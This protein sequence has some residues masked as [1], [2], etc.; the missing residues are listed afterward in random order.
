M[1]KSCIIISL[2]ALILSGVGFSQG[3]PNGSFENGVLPSSSSGLTTL[4]PIVALPSWNISGSPL[5]FPDGPLGGPVVAIT[6][7]AIFPASN[8]TNSVYL[9]TG[10]GGATTP[11]SLWQS[12]SIPLN[13]K[14][15]TFQSRAPYDPN[16]YP[17]GYYLPLLVSAAG[18]TVTPT[19]LLTD[20]SGFQT[21]GIDVTPYLGTSMEL[22]FS[23]ILSGSLGGGGAWQ[24][25]NIRYSTNPVPEPDVL[26]LL[27]F[28]GLILAFQ[29]CRKN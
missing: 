10:F 8:G 17:P 20:V 16:F 6:P 12:L 11:V 14:T 29:Y 25:D 13:V 26:T 21:F 27:S 22:R 19:Y 18:F 28:G 3:I 9:Q 2:Y 5:F 1:K 4:D 24:I 7:T 15:I 23:V